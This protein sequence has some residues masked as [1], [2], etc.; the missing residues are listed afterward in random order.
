[1]RLF[2]RYDDI[3]EN[4]NPYKDRDDTYI[5]FTE[6][7][8]VGINPL[9]EFKTPIGVYTYPLKQ[10]WDRVV[11]NTIPF[12]GDRQYVHV[13]KSIL[14]VQDV[15]DYTEAQYATDKERLQAIYKKIYARN[16]WPF[17]P[18]S[19]ALDFEEW[20][21]DA[22]PKI[23]AAKMWNATRIMALMLANEM[24]VHSPKVVA[25]WNSL[26]RS[27]GYN[28][29]SDKLGKGLIHPNEPIQAVFLTIKAFEPIAMFHNV[30]KLSAE[31][32]E[33]IDVSFLKLLDLMND[34]VFKPL[35]LKQWP[36]L[37]ATGESHN[38]EISKLDWEQFPRFLNAVMGEQ[39]IL[40]ATLKAI[41]VANATGHF[42]E[43]ATIVCDVITR[44]ILSLN[45]IGEEFH[46]SNPE[47]EFGIMQDIVQTLAHHKVM[48]FLK[49]HCISAIKLSLFTNVFL[50]MDA[51]A[52][53]N[54]AISNRLEP[55]RSAIKSYED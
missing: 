36:I 17:N 37:L 19:M 55:Y 41:R 26:L 52:N 9:S 7:L 33:K 47:K 13:L 25:A 30:R 11:N 31:T 44:K 48:P 3:V 21:E 22:H 49:K 34:P 43:I 20:E 50:V 53:S 10:I 2:E 35:V 29:F 15:S 6:I 27:L 24:L 8:K 40:K 5:T 4:L 32:L 23:P 46:Y 1:M 54:Y 14:P 39:G 42:V 28:A 12:G 18:N 51:L 16:K 45:P 38:F